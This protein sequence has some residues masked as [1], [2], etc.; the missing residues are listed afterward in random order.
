[1]SDQE[2]PYKAP[3]AELKEQTVPQGSEGSYTSAMALHL[4]QTRPW[5]RF[6]SIL[7]FISIG[8]MIIFAVMMIVGSGMGTGMIYGAAMAIIYLLLGL[9]YI[10]PVLY[11]H[12]YAS[13][14][15]RFLSSGTTEDMETAL[16]YQKSFWKFAG[17][18]ALITIALSLIMMVVGIGGA[19]AGV[20]G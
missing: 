7:G 6:I 17:I 9:L 18:L 4:K 1:M 13:Y 5:V 8:F 14:I 12:R 10:V 2:N 19:A 3:D 11:L 20:F 15:G 16:R